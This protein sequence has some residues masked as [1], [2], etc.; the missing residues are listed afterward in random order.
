MHEPGGIDGNH[1]GGAERDQILVAAMCGSQRWRPDRWGVG[2]LIAIIRGAGTAEKRLEAAGQ[3]LP[4]S[5]H[6]LPGRSPIPA[7]RA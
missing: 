6:R 3:A 5:L 7:I 4:V 1:R 2:R